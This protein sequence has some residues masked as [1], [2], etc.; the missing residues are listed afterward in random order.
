MKLRKAQSLYG[1]HHDEQE[2][3]RL[4]ESQYRQYELQ[5]EA[6]GRSQAERDVWSFEA[7]AAGAGVSGAVQ[8][9]GAAVLRAVDPAVSDHM[10]QSLNADSMARSMAYKMEG[11]GDTRKWFAGAITNTTRSLT[12]AALASGAAAAT[13]GALGVAA[14]GTA[15][16]AMSTA[17]M[18][19]TFFAT[20]ANETYA[21]SVE[22]LGH[23]KATKL[24]I[25]QGAFEGLLM[26]GF[27]AAGLGGVEKSIQ[28]ALSGG[29]KGL[30]SY[31]WKQGVKSF[32]K[33]FMAELTEEEMTTVMQRMHEAAIRNAGDPFTGEDGTFLSSPMLADMEET[34]YQTLF[35]VGSMKGTHSGLHFVLNPSR[36]NAM[37]LDSDIGD[38][39][40]RD[41]ETLDSKGDR[42]NI[43]D[44]MI[45]SYIS[46]QDE[47]S[48]FEAVSYTHLR[49]HET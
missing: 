48:Q 31:L 36:R 40:V 38:V 41:G 27:S 39:I 5:Q 49:A 28:S 9:M 23:A 16:S 34:L 17:A 37:E 43:T 44:R 42:V 15:A 4:E 45:T 24:A 47:G 21:N 22:E 7:A 1:T 46:A 18:G 11:M 6:A 2:R 12:M 14:G 3:L 8:S 20:T 25:G 10:I 30:P 33:D 19:G 35:M 26:V 32:G 13:G 29:L